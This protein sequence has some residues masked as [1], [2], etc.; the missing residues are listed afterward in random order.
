[1]NK[2]TF[3]LFS[4]LVLTLSCSDYDKDLQA[5]TAPTGEVTPTSTGHT[6]P[7]NLQNPNEGPFSE[8]KMLV[9]IGLNVIAKNVHEFSL[10]APLLESRVNQYCDDLEN[11]DPQTAQS[12][13]QAKD[14]WVT[15]MMDYHAVETIPV[16][17]LADNNR[18]LANE[19][20][21]WPALDV[22]GIDEA[23]AAMSSTGNVNSQLSYSVKGLGA[24]EYLLYDTTLSPENCNS[25]TYPKVAAWIKK[26]QAGKKRDRC[27]YA[28]FLSQEVVKKATL[29]ETAW[30]PDKNNFTKTLI[31]GSRY[32]T[33]KEAVNAVSDAL[34]EID[35]LKNQKLAR[36]L[37]F[38]ESCTRP[39]KKCPEMAEH[40]WSGLSLQAMK[41]HLI[42]FKSFF[43]GST[44]L[45]K[46]SFSFDDYMAMKKHANIAT[47]M[48]ETLDAA[49]NEI[50]LLASQGSL[51]NQIAAMD[52]TKCLDSDSDN[53]LVPLC[54]M[55]TNVRSTVMPLK[56]SVLLVLSLDA[57]AGLQG[58][59]D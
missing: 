39:D 15:T 34:F 55:Y 17:P 54:V 4:L 50:T 5:T 38:D 29:L 21:A 6:L 23:V 3:L 52:S 35:T 47:G 14:Q 24:L 42:V 13:N 1:M 44:N 59:S 30:S 43:W 28:K 9:N 48:A 25:T 2:F 53:P 40:P 58:D 51:Q 37:G 7:T 26:S 56:T 27:R 22:C 36:P 11:N 45:E 57:P 12:E 20:Y 8:E 10:Q 19:I 31:D 33:T 16:G 32:K 49:I 41:T 46:K 18:F